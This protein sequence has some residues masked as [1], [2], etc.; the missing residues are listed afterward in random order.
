M[1]YG[2]GVD[3]FREA[4][5]GYVL[6]TSG[7]GAIDHSTLLAQDQLTMLTDMNGR[8]R[9]KAK[10]PDGTPVQN[11]DGSFPYMPGYDGPSRV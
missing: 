10:M 5:R 6:R 9:F 3:A 8:P 2:K 7:R 11:P 1:P 4:L